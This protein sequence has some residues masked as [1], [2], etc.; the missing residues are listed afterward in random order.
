M[1]KGDKLYDLYC[2]IL[3][4]VESCVYCCLIEKKMDKIN[5]HNIQHSEQI[6]WWVNQIMKHIKNANLH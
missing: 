3:G 2:E 6:K 5:I 4:S 1:K